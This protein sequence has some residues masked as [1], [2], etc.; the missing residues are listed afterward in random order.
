MKVEVLH[1]IPWC[2][3]G[4][5]GTMQIAAAGRRFTVYRQVF[6]EGAAGCQRSAVGCL[7]APKGS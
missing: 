5:S 3:V 4:I 6:V 7:H 2:D 1:A